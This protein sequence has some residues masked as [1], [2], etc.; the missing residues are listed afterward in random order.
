MDNQEP[1]ERAATAEPLDAPE[2]PARRAMSRTEARLRKVTGRKTAYDGPIVAIARGWVSRDSR[3]HLLAARFLDFAVLTPEHLVLC[4][5]GFFS[6]RPR[7]RVFRE[8]L[9][10]LEVVPLG[11][12]PIR[13]VR[14]VGTFN[15]PIRMEKR[16]SEA[17]LTF[18]REL[19]ASTKPNRAGAPDGS[20]AS[21]GGR[22]S[23]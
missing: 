15:R 14:V 21:T 8:A 19:L 11:S 23:S 20:D 4:S 13:T 7:R 10:K 2:E 17:G 22:S 5:T 6:R 3:L 1:E 9:A 18:V 12:E 16:P